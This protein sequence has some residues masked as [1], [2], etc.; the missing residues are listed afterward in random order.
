MGLPVP[1][2]PIGITPEDVRIHAE[3]PE[4]FVLQEPMLEPLIRRT[5]DYQR[6]MAERRRLAVQQ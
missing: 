3:R 4:P 1:A 5:T 6:R 2:W